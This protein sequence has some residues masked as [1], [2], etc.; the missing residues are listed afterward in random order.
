VRE[1]LTAGETPSP[2][3][4]VEEFALTG[5]NPPEWARNQI[6]AVKAELEPAR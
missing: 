3:A 2:A 5:A 6:R 4:L 1:Q